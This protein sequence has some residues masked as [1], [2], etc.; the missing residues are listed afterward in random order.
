MATGE[1]LAYG[2][3]AQEH[4]KVELSQGV[5]CATTLHLQMG[6][7]NVQDAMKNNVFVL[8]NFALVST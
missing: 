7:N 2:V 8:W 5:A 6:D 3:H 1:H 4:V